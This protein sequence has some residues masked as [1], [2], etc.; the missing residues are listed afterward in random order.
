[1]GHYMGQLTQ[2][3]AF[4]V[5]LGLLA[6]G[7]GCTRFPEVPERGTGASALAYPELAP[8]DALLELIPPKGEL[9]ADAAA[10]LQARGEEAYQQAAAPLPP[11]ARDLAARGAELR[12]RSEVIAAAPVPSDLG[13]R[14]EELKRRALAAAPL[15]PAARD[16]AAR[17]A[18]LRE[19]G[20]AV[21]AAAVPSDL[22]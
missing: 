1:M 10:E 4:V 19:R 16:L 22:G 12:G 5:A 6:G 14:G 7:A 8:T 21:A 20:E 3:L 13:R 9:G 18:E 2:P 15:P 17:G 11:A